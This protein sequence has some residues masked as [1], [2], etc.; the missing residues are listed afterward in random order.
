MIRFII[1]QRDKRSYRHSEL[2]R[3]Y[4]KRLIESAFNSVNKYEQKNKLIGYADI[5]Q[6][7]LDGTHNKKPRKKIV[8]RR[9]NPSFVR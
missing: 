7:H 8:N 6:R 4:R 5:R 9:I 1:E 3:S 2:D